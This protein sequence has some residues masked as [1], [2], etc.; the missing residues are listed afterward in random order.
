MDSERALRARRQDELLRGAST[1]RK[2]QRDS[3]DC[4]P[5][6]LERKN[7]PRGQKKL[8]RKAGGK[9]GQWE[10]WMPVKRVC[11]DVG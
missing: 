6:R 8:M 2:E 4:H 5:S 7:P 9:L 10:L 1:E 3:D 11:P